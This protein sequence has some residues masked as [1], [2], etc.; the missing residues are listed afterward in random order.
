MGQ[1]S[2]KCSVCDEQILNNSTRNN[3]NRAMLITPEK[4]YTEEDYKGYGVFG[5][6]DVYTW[7]AYH[8]GETPLVDEYSEINDDVREIGV[9]IACSDEIEIKNGIRLV[10]KGC[11]RGH[12][13][14]QLKNSKDDPSQGWDD[15]EDLDD[16]DYYDDE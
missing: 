1:F 10:H 7:L 6:M 14:E 2:W 9:A 4:N 13:Y 11:F 16:E 3:F 15:E 8:I 12:T 5:G